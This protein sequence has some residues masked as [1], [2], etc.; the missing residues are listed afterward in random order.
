VTA[1][2]VSDWGRRRRPTSRRAAST[3]ARA[4]SSP[5]PSP[6]W[7]WLTLLG[8]GV[9]AGSLPDAFELLSHDVS[10]TTIMRPSPHLTWASTQPPPH[11]Q[12]TRSAFRILIAVG[13]ALAGGPPR[14]S[15]RALLTHWAPALGASV[16][17][18]FGEGVL[19]AGGW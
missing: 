13:T 10:N 7:R 12:L 3:T 9:S 19:H 2:E 6:A 11:P 4:T 17:A 1:G 8:I 5:S 14:R 18:L 16:E 15:Q